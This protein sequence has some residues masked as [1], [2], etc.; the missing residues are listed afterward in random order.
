[1]AKTLGK[2]FL[3]LAKISFVLLFEFDIIIKV[4][5]LFIIYFIRL[6]SFQKRKK[7]M[8]VKRIEIKNKITVAAAP[9]E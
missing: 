4:L 7:L 8:A 1:M 2:C 3:S 6:I 5:S 9:L